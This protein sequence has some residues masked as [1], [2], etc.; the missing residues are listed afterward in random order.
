MMNIKR[1]HYP[2][3]VTEVVENL[4]VAQGGRYIDGTLGEGGHTEAILEISQPGGQVLG[5]DADHEAIIISKK[6][7]ARFSD[8]SFFQIQNFL[9]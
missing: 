3:M 1:Y 5:I 4:N 2:V 9:K 7:L 8:C 6:R